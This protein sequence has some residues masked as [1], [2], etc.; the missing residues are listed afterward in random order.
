MANRQT[1]FHLVSTNWS[2]KPTWLH[3]VWHMSQE[4]ATKHQMSFWLQVDVSPP[5]DTTASP[6]EV[7]PFPV[8]T[9]GHKVHLMHTHVVNHVYTSEGSEVEWKCL[10]YTTSGSS[11]P[12]TNPSRCGCLLVVT[13]SP[14]ICI[15]NSSAI[16]WRILN[17]LSV[18]RFQTCCL[19][20]TLILP[21]P[22]H[23]LI[24]LAGLGDHNVRKSCS[25]NDVAINK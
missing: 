18:A 11:S 4:C 7:G 5:S 21:L 13:R 3:A 1:V 2:Y 25:I 24:Q 9:C 6:A 20:P 23:G 8:T 22:M 19:C 17:Q 12:Q 10:W 14:Y 15:F 16:N